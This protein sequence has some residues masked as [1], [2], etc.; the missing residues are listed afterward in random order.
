MQF[1]STVRTLGRVGKWTVLS[2]LAII[3][4]IVSLYENL[5]KMWGWFHR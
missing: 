1:Y 2:I 4:G 5:L 3:V